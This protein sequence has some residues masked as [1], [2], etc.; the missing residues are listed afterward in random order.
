MAG[1]HRGRAHPAISW[2]GVSQTFAL[3][4]LKL[5]SSQSYSSEQGLQAWATGAW[6]EIILF[7]LS[8]YLFIFINY[9]NTWCV[10]GNSKYKERI[11]SPVLP[12]FLCP[13]SLSLTRGNGCCLSFLLMMITPT[14]NN[15]CLLV[16]FDSTLSLLKVRNSCVT[17]QLHKFPSPLSNFVSY[18]I[19][20]FSR[21]MFLYHSV[22]ITM[23]LWVSSLILNFNLTIQYC[24][25]II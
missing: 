21:F 18:V 11:E 15:T 3:V 17:P 4:G 19:F 1:A 24:I 20:T 16:L 23:S 2:D 8:I 5:Q 6:L 12:S 13:P 25:M 9:S 22:I 10:L 14:L 7:Y